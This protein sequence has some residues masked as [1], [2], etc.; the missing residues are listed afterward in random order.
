MVLF[1]RSWYNRAGVERVMGF[2][3]QDQ[4]ETF[5]AEAPQFEAQLV[6]DGIGLYKFWLTIGQETQLKRFH[7]RRHDPLKHWKLSDIDLAALAKWDDYSQARDDLFRH[8]HSEQAPWTV[9]R[10]NDKRRARLNIMR[11][12]LASI[13]YSEKDKDVVGEP[14]AKPV[15]SGESFFASG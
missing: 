10:A 7:D 15:G 3:S 12:V 6:R 4:V 1:D 11:H 2:C 5:L 13:D 8:T 14:D 9:V